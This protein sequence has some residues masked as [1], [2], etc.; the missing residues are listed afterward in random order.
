MGTRVLHLSHLEFEENT[1][2]PPSFLKARKLDG[3]YVL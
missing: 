3:R 2:K 1:F